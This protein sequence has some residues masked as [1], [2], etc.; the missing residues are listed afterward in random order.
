MA[1]SADE[2]YS[3]PLADFVPERDAL[4]R[5]L[6]KDGDA[7]EAA[8]VKALRKPS[9]AAW[10]VNQAVRTSPGDLEA[11]LAAGA[12]LRQAQGHLMK[13]GEASEVH[14]AGAE[15]RR[16]V[17]RL[18][19]HAEKAL[20]DAGSAESLARVRE[21]LQAVASD[22]ELRAEVERGVVV[23]ERRASGFGLLGAPAE[24]S[25]RSAGS[26]K[27]AP[28]DGRKAAKAREAE[29]EEA[30]ARKA[31]LKDAREDAK[32]ARAAEA[33]AEKA[34]GEAETELA[35]LREA[36]QAARHAADRA[37]ERVEELS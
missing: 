30:A 10:A 22:E 25:G 9:V 12:A 6:K 24:A 17:D 16:A 1:A 13:G 36:A 19:A 26:K 2:L 20:G 33:K 28:K 4:A 21:T 35:R 7:E 31:E 11:L 3:L 5:S 37:A 29:R 14:E 8:R 27:Q 18:L 15:E 32:K 23:K 34:A